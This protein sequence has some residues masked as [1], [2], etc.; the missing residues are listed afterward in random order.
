MKKT[1]VFLMVA[2]FILSM[3]AAC[4]KKVETPV[5]PTKVKVG[6]FN[7]ISS[8]P[9]FI[10]RDEGY[11]AEQG[12]DVELI[13][14]GSASNEMLPA[15]MDGKLDAAGYAVTVAIYNAILQGGDVKFVAD[16]GYQNP[17]NCITDAWVARKESLD[18][19]LITN[20]SS[21]SGKKVAFPRGTTI[22]FTMDL[23]LDESGL[24]QNIFEYSNINDSAAR[25]EAVKN[26]SVDVTFLSEPWVTKAKT[27]GVEVWMPASKIVPGMSFGGV[28][29]GPTLLNGDPKIAKAFLVAYLKAVKQFNQG[30]TDRNVEIIANYTKLSPEDI[31]VSCW[32][33]FKADGL[34]DTEYFQ[35]YQDWALSKGLINGEI[36]LDQIWTSKYLDA[37]LQEL[38]KK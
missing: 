5:E 8:A 19:G 7:Y 17:D 2:M 29:F 3:L 24:T 37:A 10:A 38:N 12:L 28:V 16:K 33:N 31:K 6:V 9:F 30:K 21:L 13:D 27:S 20:G 11:F 32:T 34:I 4:A 22:E 18:A 14:F 1:L 25:I 36:Q 26:K 15:V 35:K 23:L